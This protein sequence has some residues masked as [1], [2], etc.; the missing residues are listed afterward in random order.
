[1]KKYILLP[2]AIVAAIVLARFA[3][4]TVDASE[5]AYVTVL[6]EHV[7]TYDGND[8][9]NG[10]GLHFGWPW[11]I[12]QVQR[13]DRR[14]QQFDLPPKDE[15]T[16]DA[17]GNKIDKV[18]SIEGYVCWKISD[19]K[20]VDRF[21][22]RIGA[23]SRAREILEPVIISRL[24][25]AISERS[26]DD[27]VN[28]VTLDPATGRTK[29]DDT[30]EKL[31]SVLIIALRQHL[32]DEYGIDLVDIRLRRFSHPSSVR[33]SIFQRIR[34]E[35]SRAAAKYEEDGNLQANLIKTKADQEVREAIAA[36]RNEEERIK[37]QADIESMKIRS[38]AYA[39]DREFYEFLKKLEKMQSILG[40]SKTMLL[41]ST[42]RPMFD[43]LFNMPRPKAEAPKDDK[44]KGGN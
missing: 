8:G 6:G 27:L 19:V 10:A 25:A 13:L 2:L 16:H 3:F 29:V 26:M 4:Y 44:K 24:G 17:Q 31:N 36:A 1:M 5:Y 37:A 18:L 35:R 43:S 22:K 20:G 28:T 38:E 15:L 34:A 11:P 7:A 9:A 42:H 40:D 12:E 39:Q 41:L 23:V 14:L 21:V 30:L 32:N 33:D